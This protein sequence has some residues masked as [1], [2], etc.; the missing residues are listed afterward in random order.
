M[1]NRR[2]LLF[3]PLAV[4]MALAPLPARAITA[5]GAVAHVEALTDQA[6]TTLQRSDLTME[7]REVAFRRILRQGFG[8]D[9]I[10]RFV[11]GR[12]WAKATPEQQA[13]YLA[14]FGEFLV[15]T[16][17]KRLGGFSGE[18]LTV[19]GTKESSQTVI[20]QTRLD[21]PGASPVEAGWQ[22]FQRGDFAAARAAWQPLA[23]A[24]DAPAQFN[25][26]VMF[27]EGWGMAVDHGR[28][29]GLW[30]EAAEQGHVRAQHNLALL[31]IA[32]DDGA[33]DFAQAVFWLKQA[34]D[35][36]FAR[37]QYSLAKM[38]AD[39]LGVARD[40]DAA[41]SLF[42]AA[43]E[44]GFARAQ[45]NLGK[46][47]RDGRGTEDDAAQ[48]IAWF[49][50]AAE[51]G[52]AKAQYRLAA[53]YAGGHDVDADVLEALKWATLAARQ[54]HPPAVELR[55]ALAAAAGADV[56]AEAARLVDGFTIVPAAPAR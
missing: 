53:R 31:H 13:D 4:V 19:V 24:G 43:G 47:F 22:A 56:A 6:I 14:L 51:Q 42:L 20:V 3:V 1:I 34:A 54:G 49:R 7:Q 45:Y 36:G 26:G 44:A 15:K 8:V 2:T 28:A 37:S 32:G 29:R 30:Q 10:G 5:T 9:F 16:S 46:M 33:Q 18:T 25:L 55:G 39:G 48:S 27:D 41:F 21:R 12:A 35:Q 38:Y 50:R 23:K 52:Y 11:L 40:D 17:A